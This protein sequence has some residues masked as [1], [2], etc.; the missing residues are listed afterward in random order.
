MNTQA[1]QE[2]NNV[3]VMFPAS[4]NFPTIEEMEM[5]SIVTPAY[6]DERFDNDDI[7][8]D[9]DEIYP[10]LEAFMNRHKRDEVLTPDDRLVMKINNQIEMINEAKERIKFY[11]E[12]LDIFMPRK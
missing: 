9:E 6:E 8:I 4:K 7:E 5:G 3:L 2:E 10:S 1:K 12:E 11:L